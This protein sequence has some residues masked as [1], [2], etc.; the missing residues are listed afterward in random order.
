MTVPAPPGEQYSTPVERDAVTQ[1]LM[2]P[3]EAGTGSWRLELSS[4]QEPE[5]LEIWIHGIFCFVTHPKE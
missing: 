4:Y 1:T 2:L 3:L 5:W